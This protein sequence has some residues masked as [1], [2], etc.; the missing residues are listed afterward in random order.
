MRREYLQLEKCRPSWGLGIIYTFPS[1]YVLGYLDFVASRL[2]LL[3]RSDRLV[4]T[5]K[6]HNRSQ[7]RVSGAIA[8]NFSS[9]IGPNCET[10]PAPS[11]KIM[12]PSRAFLAA[13]VT[14]S[15]ND[16]AYSI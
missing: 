13:R 3:R 4:K 1:T 15:S 11:V 8:F 14:A 16:T 9:T 12:S 5:K 6:E 2:M 10:D 7:V